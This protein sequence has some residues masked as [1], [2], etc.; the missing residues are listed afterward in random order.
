MNLGRHARVLT[1]DEQGVVLAHLANGQSAQRDTLMFLLSIDAGLKAKEISALDWSMATDIDGALV[2]EI[3]GLEQ[4]SKGR[5]GPVVMSSRLFAALS[6]FA[7]GKPLAGR[8]ILS[9]RGKPMS[10][11][12]VVNFFW[13]L[14]QR[15]GFE[16]C[17]S[18]SGRRTAITRWTSK[19]SSVG[20]AVRDVQMLAGHSSPQMTRRYIE[21]R[22]GVGRKLVE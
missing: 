11:Q 12:V 7:D 9:Q 2:D 22:E 6:A 4:V 5:S 13:L 21:T 18:H 14:Y 10:A 20:G 15:L 3:Q 8:V 16:G 17:S 1:E 19:V